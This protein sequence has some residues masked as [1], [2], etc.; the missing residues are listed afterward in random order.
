MP[1]ICPTALILKSIYRPHIII[2]IS[3]KTSCNYYLSSC[4]HI[5]SSKKIFPLNVTYMPYVLITC[6]HQWGSMPVNMPYMNSPA[7]T[8][9]PAAL[10]TDDNNVTM[11]MMMLQP[12]YRLWLI[13]FAELA[14]GQ[15]S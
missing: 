4:C 1:H 5:F 7:L 15:I 3:Q 8:V 6:M 11:M 2:H 10:Y 14:T 12:D 9:C 13:T